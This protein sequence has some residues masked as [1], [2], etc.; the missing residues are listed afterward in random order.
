MY[1]KLLL[2]AHTTQVIM[3]EVWFGHP[4]LCF[5][6]CLMQNMFKS[7]QKLC[8]WW[9]K[10]LFWSSGLKTHVFE[11]HLNSFSCFSFMKSIGLSVFCIN[12]Y[13]FSKKSSF[14]E[15]RSIECVFRPIE[16]PLIFNHDFLPG[17]I[18]ILS[19]LNRSKLENFQF[20]SFW[21]NIF[22]CVI[23]V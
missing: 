6:W 3:C 12:F 13:N 19:M 14:L 5:L 7:W 15:F 23:Y 4:R 9:L 20:L 10:T 11:K 2:I 22:S 8:F 21:P 16:N 18:G 1:L 17:S